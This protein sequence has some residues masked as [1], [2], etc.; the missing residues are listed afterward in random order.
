MRTIC[1]IRYLI[2][3]SGLSPVIFDLSL[4]WRRSVFILVKTCYRTL[5]YDGRWNLVA[6]MYKSLYRLL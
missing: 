6:I 5:K 1:D 4:A 3:T 2:S